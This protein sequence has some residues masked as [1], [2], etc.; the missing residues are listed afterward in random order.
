LHTLVS[1]LLKSQDLEIRVLTSRPPHEDSSTQVPTKYLSSYGVDVLSKVMFA[2]RSLIYCWLHPGQYDFVHINGA[3][4]NQTMCLIAVKMWRK[5]SLVKLTLLG[6]DDPASLEAQKLGW[7]RRRLALLSDVFVCV[8]P[9]LAARCREDGHA[10]AKRIVHIPN[11]VDV[12]R[13]KPAG[14][15]RRVSLRERLGIGCGEKVAIYTGN[16]SARKSIERLLEIWQRVSQDQ[17]EAKLILVGPARPEYLRC[18]K[19]RIGTL[20]LHE[21]VVLTGYVQSVEL[22]YQ[23][24]DLFVFASKQEGLP[25]SVLE[26]MACALP[27]VAY[28][29]PGL[30]EIV[31]ADMLIPSGELEKYAELVCKLL[32]DKP[33][34]Q[35]IGRRNRRLIIKRFSIEKVAESYRDLY[36]S[37]IGPE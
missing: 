7:F 20:Q 23:V 14:K 31:G 30:E 36:A 37:L 27:V 21:S 13:Y 29:I 19:E 8:S 33:V 12:G 3:Y 24:A 1:C 22:Y 10:R 9:Q 5:K 15:S 17:S 6:E 34:R 25:N 32:K 16:L 35:G 26:A 4:W 18:L 11:G 2:V 28:H